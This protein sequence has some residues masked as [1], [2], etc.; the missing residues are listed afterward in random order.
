MWT[1]IICFVILRYMKVKKLF[2]SWDSVLKLNQRVSFYFQYSGVEQLLD[3]ILAV[4]FSLAFVLPYSAELKSAVGKKFVKE[5]R[6]L[7]VTFLLVKK[8]DF[9]WLK[10]G[11]A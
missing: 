2:A 3:K 5:F 9:K 8:I 6:N 1:L 11:Q 7:A 4:F 10:N